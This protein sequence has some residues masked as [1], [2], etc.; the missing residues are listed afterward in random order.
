MF[1]GKINQ[2]GE[3]KVA[4]I[5]GK[6]HTAAGMG[7]VKWSWRDDTGKLHECLIHEVLYFPMSPINILSVTSFAR[8]SQ[9]KEE[10]GIDTKQEYSRFYWDFGKGSRIIHHPA[11]NLPELAINEGFSLATM[12]R[13]L[14]CKV[15][16]P[17]IQPNHSCCFTDLDGESTDGSC[18]SCD[19]FALSSD[20]QMEAYEVGETIFYSKDGFSTLA[21]ITAITLDKNNVLRYSLR[22]SGGDE[23]ST[24]REHIRSPDTPDVGWIP[25]SV[26]EYSRSAAELSEEQIKEITSP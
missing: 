4:T 7:T 15:V 13:A 2:V 20:L 26:P 12:F 5:G 25:S 3:H 18:T 1:V 10:T 9:D 17:S 6:G 16:N 19:S 14:V 23:V 11:S 24:T 22:T 21:K 8:Q